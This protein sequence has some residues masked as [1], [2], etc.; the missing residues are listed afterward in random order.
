MRPNS[1]THTFLNGKASG[2]DRAR[3]LSLIGAD[4]FSK[5]SAGK[6]WDSSRQLNCPLSVNPEKHSQD[7]LI[8]CQRSWGWVE[9]LAQGNSSLFSGEGRDQRTKSLPGTLYR[10]KVRLVLQF[11]FGLAATSDSMMDQIKWIYLPVTG[12]NNETHAAVTMATDVHV[13]RISGAVI[14]KFLYLSRV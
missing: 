5:D 9:N 2:D 12:I 7:T 10:Y 11:L 4:Q 1:S 3:L 8:R 13:G 6:K 14:L